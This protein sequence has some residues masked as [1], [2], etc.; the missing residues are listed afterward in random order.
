MLNSV[1]TVEQNRAGSH[2]K[3]GWEIFTNRVIDLLGESERKI[4]FLLWGS[5]AQK[6]GE[7]VDEGKKN[8]VLAAPHPSPLSAHRGFFGCKHFLN[9]IIFKVGGRRADQLVVVMKDVKM[10]EKESLVDFESR[11]HS[12]AVKI[13]RLVR[14]KTL[15]SLLLET[16]DN[17]YTK[18]N[19][20]EPR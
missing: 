1:L 11:G 13:A 6:K 20:L 7:L 15:N 4:V 9:A 16:I 17:L 14:E 3:K 19:E 8:L 2:Q 12:G 10:E 5:Y 18:I